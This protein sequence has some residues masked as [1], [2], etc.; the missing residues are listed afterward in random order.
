MQVV[1]SQACHFSSKGG[2]EEG[3]EEFKVSV[4]Y[5]EMTSQPGLPETLFKK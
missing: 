4:D 2:G 5:V 3:K 1:R